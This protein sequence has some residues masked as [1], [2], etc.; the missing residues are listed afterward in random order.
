MMNHFDEMTD[1]DHV[2]LPKPPLESKLPTFE[3]DPQSNYDHLDPYHLVH[4]V[5]LLMVRNI[6]GVTI[7]TQNLEGDEEEISPFTHPPFILDERGENLSHD[8][9][10][11][12]D[13]KSEEVSPSN[14]NNVDE[15]ISSIF[16]VSQPIYDDYHEHSSKDCDQSVEAIIS[17]NNSLVA[18]EVTSKNTSVEMS[19][20]KPSLVHNH[21]RPHT[22]REPNLCTT[23]RIDCIPSPRQS[24]REPQDIFAFRK[25][26][27][28][29]K[30]TTDSREKG[31]KH[32]VFNDNTNFK[33]DHSSNPNH[34][35]HPL[36]VRHA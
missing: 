27:N 36:T 5:N 33:D 31:T 15:G 18:N 19:R 16:K 35:P 8:T 7:F 17:R 13:D 21:V 10:F 4:K 25:L 22:Q 24:I 29:P 34:E 26:P 11:G 6:Q 9:N 14:L 20:S 3:Y 1:N 30:N 12:H 28:Y 23:M 32:F 2:I